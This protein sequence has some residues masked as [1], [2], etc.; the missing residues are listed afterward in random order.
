MSTPDAEIDF[1]HEGAMPRDVAD[2]LETVV[3]AIDGDPELAAAV[4]HLPPAGLALSE[5]HE[6]WGPE[7]AWDADDNTDPSCSCGRETIGEG[8]QQCGSPLCP[9][10]FETGAGFC[11]GHPDKDY[12]PEDD[13]TLSP[14]TELDALVA[15][16][17][18]VEPGGWVYDVFFPPSYDRSDTTTPFTTREHAEE[19]RTA[20]VM[21]REA[22]RYPGKASPVRKSYPAYSTD[23]A[24]SV[25]ARDLAFKLGMGWAVVFAGQRMESKEI[26]FFACLQRVVRAPLSAV[27]RGPTYCRIQFTAAAGWK[28]GTTPEHAVAL[29]IVGAGDEG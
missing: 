24:A 9:I 28:I 12:H 6:E 18:G 2:V 26:H 27:E 10:C 4:D 19:H 25:E 15:A 23:A 5:A 20:E 1:V 3:A 11:S 8:C 14:G 16:K 13:E 29:A 7:D 17:L 21:P 22:A